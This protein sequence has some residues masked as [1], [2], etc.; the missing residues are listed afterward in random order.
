MR[1]RYCYVG[2]KANV[3]MT[4]ETAERALAFSFAEARRQ[5]L[6]HVEIIF[7]GGE[8]LLEQDLLF[9]ICEHAC[10]HAGELRVSFK[11]STNGLLLAEPVLGELARH[12]VYVSVSIDGGPDVQDLHRRDAADRGS[13]DRLKAVTDRL[14]TLNPCASV[15]CVCTPRTAD[16]LDASVEWLFERGFA[17]VTPTL[18]WTASWTRGDLDVLGRSCERLAEWYV[19]E[20]LAGEK[21]YLSLFDERIRTWAHGPPDACER[22][23]FGYRQ[24]S[25]SPTG[26]LYPCV[27]FVRADAGD[28]FCIGDI[29]RGFIAAKRE[30]LHAAAGTEKSECRDC[31]LRSRCAHWCACVNYQTAGRVDRVGPLVCE[32]ERILIPLADRIANRLWKRRDPNFLHKQY[33]PAFPVLSFAER[34]TVKEVSHG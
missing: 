21:F 25:V 32:F 8:P 5:G 29:W 30:S 18:D 19:S 28:E 20:T 15:T 34:L 11:V 26:R 33:N 13:S 22:C 4:E 14:L 2:K 17:Y 6:G 31:A 3:S 27:Q 16:R 7:F 10:V 9:H 1:C 23:S 12:N 24:F